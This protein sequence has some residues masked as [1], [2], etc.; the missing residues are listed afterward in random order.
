MP[1][2]MPENVIF[3]KRLGD[4]LD[5]D[6]L[7]TPATWKT[8]VGVEIRKFW[9]GNFI[10]EDAEKKNTTRISSLWNDDA[11][12]FRFECGYDRINVDPGWQ[13]EKTPRLWERDVVEL[14]IRPA[15]VDEYFEIEVSP[16][17]QWLDLFVRI[18]RVDHDLS[19]RS[20]MKSRVVLDKNR[21][22]WDAELELP[23]KPMLDAAQVERPPG[24]NDL[25]RVNFYR[26]TGQEPDRK[27]Y[28]WQPTYTVHPDFHVPAAFGML[29]FVE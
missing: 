1:V 24:N 18:P 26:V 15:G 16:L 8:T 7:P 4:F 28:T 19:W 17:G 23:W 11:V 14:F 21:S 12:F 3:S 5:S 25:W 9:N 27:Y 13:T 29:M 6:G 10:R 22:L 20:G 2:L